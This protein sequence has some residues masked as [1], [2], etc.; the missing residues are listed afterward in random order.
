M[1]PKQTV[2]NTHFFVWDSPDRF[3]RR[4]VSLECIWIGLGRVHKVG[5]LAVSRMVLLLELTEVVDE[6]SGQPDYLRAKARPLTGHNH[7]T[8]P[9]CGLHLGPGAIWTVQMHTVRD[10]S[11]NSFGLQ[12]FGGVDR[13]GMVGPSSWQF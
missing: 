5:Y 8:L 11:L 2:E 9:N 6:R 3:A 1:L 12:G 7:P 4:K 13:G 10:H